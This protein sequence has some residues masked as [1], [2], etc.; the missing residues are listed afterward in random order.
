M[1]RKFKFEE[2]HYRDLSAIPMSTRYKLDRVGLQLE[3]KT[4]AQ[5]SME[6]RRVLCHL[7]VRSQGEV[8]C[9]EEF[10]A[11]L[12]RRNKGKIEKRDPLESRRERA[13]WENL[14]RIPEQVYMRVLKLKKI[15]TPQEWID[16]DDLERYV[17]YRLSLEKYNDEV[18]LQA[19]EEFLRVPRLKAERIS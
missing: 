10:L 13:E 15:L 4:W 19:F 16:L 11:S 14:N 3:P 7:S 6:E 8:E 1:F 18:F 12:L 17:L 2:A 5:F 9:Y